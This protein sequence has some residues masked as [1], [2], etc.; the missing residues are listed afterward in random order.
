MC[1]AAEPVTA[2]VHGLG[3]FDA[4][5]L[6]DLCPQRDNGT[7]MRA[8]VFTDTLLDE[9]EGEDDDDDEDAAQASDDQC[10][11]ENVLHLL[12][13]RGCDNTYVENTRRHFVL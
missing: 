1:A 6:V 10:K 5:G 12:Q 3:K 8:W 2:G 11:V 13:S 4:I 9:D 7:K